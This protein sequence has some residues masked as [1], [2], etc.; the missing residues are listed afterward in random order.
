[1]TNNTT[2]KKMS[3]G[4]GNPRAEN[5]INEG[6]LHASE[7]T[8]KAV[9]TLHAVCA[10]KGHTLDCADPAS[11]WAERWGPVRRLPIIDTARRFFAQIGSRL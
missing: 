3:T 5:T 7:R 4:E 10:V 2:P 8:D 11:Y 1:M 6:C 9:S